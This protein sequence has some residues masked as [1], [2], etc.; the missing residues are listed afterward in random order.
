MRTRLVVE[1]KRGEILV[2][3]DVSDATVDDGWVTWMIG[4]DEHSV[5]QV[6]L[7]RVEFRPAASQSENSP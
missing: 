7:E 1:N 4:E 6:D 5:A 3:E 2:D